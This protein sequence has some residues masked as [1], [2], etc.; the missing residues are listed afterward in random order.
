MLIGTSY[1]M[2]SSCIPHRAMVHPY[3]PYAALL[4]PHQ[5]TVQLAEEAALREAAKTDFETKLQS[6]PSLI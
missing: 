6:R 1:C 3:H 4:V 5:A 2:H